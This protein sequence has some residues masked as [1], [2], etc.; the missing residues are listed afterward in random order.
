MGE[1]ELYVLKYVNEKING[2]KDIKYTCDIEEEYA[3]N[4][5]AHYIERLLSKRYMTGNEWAQIKDE[6]VSKYKN[7]VAS[8]D[9][10]KLTIT[11]IG[12]KEIKKNL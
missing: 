10:Q 6:E 11:R 7:K 8:I 5:I 4:E 1:K 9:Y 2:N 3:I 12:T